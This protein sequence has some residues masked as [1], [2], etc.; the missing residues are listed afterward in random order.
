MYKYKYMYKYINIYIYIKI[1]IYKNKSKLPTHDN[2][3]LLLF[4]HLHRPLF[5]LQ[6]VGGLKFVPQNCAPTRQPKSQFQNQT[7]WP[8]IGTPQAI[9]RLS[10]VWGAGPSNYAARWIQLQTRSA[11]NMLQ[12][13]RLTWGRFYWPKAHTEKLSAH[14]SSSGASPTWGKTISPM[15]LSKAVSKFSTSSSA[16]RP[17]SAC[18]GFGTRRAGAV[19]DEVALSE[20]MEAKQDLLRIF[21]GNG[22]SNKMT[23]LGADGL[24]A[25]WQ[26]GKLGQ[27]LFLDIPVG[28]LKAC[29]VSI[30]ID[31]WLAALTS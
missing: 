13:T 5:L 9:Y 16:G 3:S 14:K 30:D 29:P 27:R 18:S 19:V 11:Q 6:V 28:P 26:V 4:L 21:T 15:A 25:W 31:R 20:V 17:S 1:E 24:M 22:E 7:I 12:W 10:G 8:N 23:L 2:M